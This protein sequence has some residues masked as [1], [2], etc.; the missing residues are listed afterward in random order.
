MPETPSERS[1]VGEDP[2]VESPLG[3]PNPPPSAGPAEPVL[4]QPSIVDTILDLDELLS[5]DVRRAEKMAPFCTEPWREARIDELKA[6]LDLLTDDQGN[7][8]PT[9]EASLDEGGR[10]AV[11]VAAELEAERVLYGKAFRSVRMRQMPDEEW[12]EFRTRW[13]EAI[14]KEPP[15]PNAMFDELIVASAIKPT[16]SPAQIPQMRSKLGHPVMD[17]LGWTAWQVNSS[18]GV[19]IPKSP[20]SSHV[21]RRAARAMS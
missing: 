10:T 1:L 7:P 6:E 21:L 19:S 3:I 5:A 15:Y 9:P 20:L 14:A 17:L 8:L 16:V 4:D 18:S 12:V 11:T 2:P 13:R